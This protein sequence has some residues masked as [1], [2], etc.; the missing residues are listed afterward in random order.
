MPRPLPRY[1]VLMRGVALAEDPRGRCLELL[2]T[3]DSSSSQWQL[4]KTKVSGGA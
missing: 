3:Y 2:Q 4:G 1:K